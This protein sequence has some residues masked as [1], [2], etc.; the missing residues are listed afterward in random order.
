LSYPVKSVSDGCRFTVVGCEVD[1]TCRTRGL[2]GEE[3]CQYQFV[4][5]QFRCTLST[6]ILLI[7]MCE[8]RTSI[9]S[10]ISSA[11]NSCRTNALAFPTPSGLVSAN[12]DALG[13]G[14]CGI[15]AIVVGGVAGSSGW[16]EISDDGRLRSLGSLVEVKG[17]MAA[18]NFLWRV[19]SM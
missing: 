14:W 8:E 1:F 13:R 15:R 4:R 18:E 5:I 11:L 3:I 9:G 12:R 6:V 2:G 7:V 10:S 16:E 19:E 17:D